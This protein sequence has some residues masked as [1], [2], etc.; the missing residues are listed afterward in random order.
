MIQGTT[1]QVAPVL[2][3]QPLD[4]WALFRTVAASGGYQAVSARRCRAD[5]KAALLPSSVLSTQR[6][7][8]KCTIAHCLFIY[9][10]V[11]QAEQC[12][13][14]CWQRHMSAAAQIG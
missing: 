3:H 14:G 11:R 2:D 13:E 5:I 10:L 1:P 6:R 7:A 9:S 8:A 4:L 12:C